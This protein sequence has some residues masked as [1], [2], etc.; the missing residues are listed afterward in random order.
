MVLA[1]TPPHREIDADPGVD[2]RLAMLRLAV[3]GQPGLEVSTAEVERGGAS[4]TVDTLEALVEQES[5]SQFTLIIGADQAAAFGKWRQPERIGEL[6]TVAVA[7]RPEYDSDAALAAVERATGK[8]PK[9]FAMPSIEISSSSIRA[10][11]TAGLPIAHLVPAGIA[12]VVEEAGLY[13]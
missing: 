10:Q 13:Q 3:I 5:E 6:A 1:A 11:A 12:E 7:A 9:S 2:L 8:P 4:W